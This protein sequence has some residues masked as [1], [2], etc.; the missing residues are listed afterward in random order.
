MTSFLGELTKRA[1]KFASANSTTI[2]TT[3]GVVGTVSTAYLA[4]RA[5]LNTGAEIRQEEVDRGEVMDTREKLQFVWETNLWRDYI[6]AVVTCSTTVVCIVMSQRI[7]S[8]QAAGLAA[9]YTLSE[10]AMDEYQKKV[11]EKIGE[12][13]EEEVRS[14]ILRDR[15]REQDPFEDDSIEVHGKPN[16]SVF[17]DKFGQMYVWST[18][19]EI[20]A[21]MND[22]GR[23]IIN[24]GYA[25]LADFYYRMDMP[26]PIYA[27]EIGW[28][29]DDELPRPTFSSA[30]SPGEKPINAFEFTVNPN[31]RY[32]RFH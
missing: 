12:K 15:V 8:K 2:L 9:A 3:I 6:P 24:V 20:G 30:L 7:G 18:R 13:K 23:T 16:G 5:A 19:E 31:A 10:R 25:T 17:H 22:I 26:A 21:A 1:A 28:C 29:S 27:T 11:V 32:L 4:G 14:E